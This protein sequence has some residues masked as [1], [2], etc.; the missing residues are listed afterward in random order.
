MAQ[1]SE[2][3]DLT[4][5]VGLRTHP[6]SAFVRVWLFVVAAGFGSI[7]VVIEEFD[8]VRMLLILVAGVVVGSA[9]GGAVWWFTTFVIDGK[10]L[11]IDS[12][13][14]TK[15]SRR[16]PYQRIQSVDIAQPLGARIFGL[17]E[18]RI[19]MAGGDD[20]RTQLQYLKYADAQ[21]LRS[22][23]LD[24]AHQ[25]DPR[26]ADDDDDDATVDRVATA[27]DRSRTTETIATVSP[28]QL[29]VATLISLDL[30]ASAVAVV[31]ILIVA[32]IVSGFVPLLSAI[33]PVGSWFVQIIASRVIAQWGFTLSRTSGGLRIERGLLSR[34]SQTVPFDRVQGIAVQQ[35]FLWRRLGW[36][37]LEV[38]VAGYASSGDDDDSSTSTLLPVGDR[39]L[40][41][42][43]IFQLMPE[44]R[45][46][47]IRLIPAPRRSAWF[48]PIGW[49]FRAAGA[50]DHAFVSR[51]GWLQ[52]RHDVVPHRKTQSVALEQGPL[53][54][55]LGVADVAVHTPDGP[56]SAKGKHLSSADALTLA[57]GQL[58]R[59]RAARD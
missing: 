11:R 36:Q 50:D 56:V 46:G 7:Q 15:K 2:S 39:R 38:D 40:A 27:A 33:V 25:N 1:D 45:P 55:R 32:V 9:V 59:A 44:V 34:T 5:G 12:G 22:L 21:R 30:I 14:L 16:I 23:L 20:S 3:A 52:R 31:V 4:P 54:R 18:L 8:L 28:Q 58:D 42:H 29:V 57:Y 41:Q 19:E 35:P 26:A 51:R 43:V 47:D 6:A 53:Q 17:S 10:E 24:R 37:R 48:A 13:M 49:R